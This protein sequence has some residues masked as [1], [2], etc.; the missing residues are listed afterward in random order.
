MFVYERSRNIYRT[1]RHLSTSVGEY[2]TIDIVQRD[3]GAAPDIRG[4]IA[5]R[6]WRQGARLLHNITRR[7]GAIAQQRSGRGGDAHT[8]LARVSRLQG[9]PRRV[10]NNHRRGR[11]VT[12]VDMAADSD[13]QIYGLYATMYV[14]RY[15]LIDKEGVIRMMKFEY[16]EGDLREILDMAKEIRQ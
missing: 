15:Y 7:Q 3:R 4:D 10:A 11:G 6:R 13:K 8:L 12:H 16:Y 9:T 5:R 2:V 14:P 1:H